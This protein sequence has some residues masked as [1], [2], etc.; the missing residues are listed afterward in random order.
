MF[1]HI[2]LEVLKVLGDKTTKVLTYFDLLILTWG[3]GPKI[4][5]QKK[6]KKKKK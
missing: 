5:T 2:F 6:K 3:N 4:I 1:V